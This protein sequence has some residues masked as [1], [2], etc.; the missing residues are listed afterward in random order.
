[1][2]TDLGWQRLRLLI[3]LRCELSRRL[4]RAST[5]RQQLLQRRHPGLAQAAQPAQGVRDNGVLQLA[6]K[7]I[8]QDFVAYRA[9]CESVG[10]KR[11]K[12]A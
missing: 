5:N 7:D 12:V 8:E 2:L 4:R 9:K 1:M 11:R 6:I 10:Q 3:R